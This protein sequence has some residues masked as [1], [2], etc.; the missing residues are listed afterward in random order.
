MLL[1]PAL[2]DIAFFA[3]NA[4]LIERLYKLRNALPRGGDGFDQWAA[5]SHRGEKP[6]KALP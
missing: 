1:A 4:K 6:A 5:A 3:E 2:R